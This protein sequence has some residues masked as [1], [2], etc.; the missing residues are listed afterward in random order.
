MAG[1]IKLLVEQIAEKR[2]RGISAI[3]DTTIAKITLK[4]V[5]VGHYTED[6]PDDPEVLSKLRTIAQEL[7]VAL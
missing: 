2:S 5:N 6:S 7:G 4:G 3:K 1:R